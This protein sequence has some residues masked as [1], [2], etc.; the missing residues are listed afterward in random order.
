MKELVVDKR[1]KIEC[2]KKLQEYLL[3]APVCH[4]LQRIIEYRKIKEHKEKLIDPIL[5]IGCGDGIF[6]SM[7]F[8]DSIFMGIDL[9]MSEIALARRKKIYKN[10]L[11][12]SVEKLP[13]SS[14]SFKTVSSNCVIEHIPNLENALKEIY[15]VLKK[16]G[17]FIFTVPSK[18]REVYSPFPWMRQV[19]INF[20]PNLMNKLLRLLWQEY[21]FYSP[22][23]WK[24]KLEQTGFEVVICEYFFPKEAYAT[25]GRFLFFSAI[26]LITK[27]IFNRWILFSSWRNLFIPFIAKYLEKYYL[28]E[29][30]DGTE[31]LLISY[32]K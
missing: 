15:R 12:G 19:G 31:L 28:L 21:H 11:V 7:L 5:D 30:K 27:K 2:K 13:F 14:E 1:E 24:E 23:V 18:L 32:K 29:G 26:S 22:G 20:F 10:L 17:Y 25:Y 3:H 16:D 4:V 9:S 6:A 8:D